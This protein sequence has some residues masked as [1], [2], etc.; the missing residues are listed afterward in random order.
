MK[1]LPFVLPVA[2]FLIACFA[3]LSTA[4]C[5]DFRI[6]NSIY[7][8]GQS[9]PQSQGTTIF[10]GGQV[11][12]F[13]SD[14][15]EVIVFDKAR[16]QF[17]MLDVARRQRCSL[18]TQEVEKFVGRVRQRLA[19]Q[20]NP[21]LKFLAEPEFQESFDGSSAELTLKSPWVTYRA[22]VLTTGP[23]VAAQY[24]EFSDWYAQLN[25][26]LNPA[27]RPPFVRMK[28]NEGI[29]R[30]K[31]VAK[32]VHL[33]VVMGSPEPPLQIESR[34]QLA[35]QLDAS[36]LNRIAEA[37]EYLRTFTVVSLEEYRKAK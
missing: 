27:S 23:D 5:D 20:S 25:A 31:G 15:A 26:M 11:Y 35:I 28:L 29:A 12:D 2:E 21:K 16:D 6:D 18:G 17:I 37:R 1:T 14:P 22:H 10:Y 30:H 32:D 33:L 3:C 34:H 19:G 36:D 24:R 7:L 8:Q 13:L 4:R 9:T